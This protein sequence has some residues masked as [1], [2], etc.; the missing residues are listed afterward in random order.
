ME[1][2]I[3]F[4]QLIRR[5]QLGLLSTEEQSE[6]DEW[7]MDQPEAIER[8]QQGERR[9]LTAIESAVEERSPSWFGQAPA[10]AAMWLVLGIG[11]GLFGG[12][13]LDGNAPGDPALASANVHLL[14]TVR[15]VE[16]DAIAS[17]DIS[18]AEQ[19]T[20][21]LAQPDF[22]GAA[23]FRVT[24]DRYTGNEQAVDKNSSRDWYRVW[25]G[26]VGVGNEDMLAVSVRTEL[27]EPGIHRVEV[28][29]VDKNSAPVSTVR[30]LFMVE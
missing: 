22:E 16:V 17:Y 26:V 11:A 6:L 23:E 24:F 18:R 20:T 15:S 14:D 19:W 10:M 21:F 13:L 29:G 30:H 28:Q 27:M 12:S 1:N 7:L 4:Q 9:L 8:V 5:D 25:S 3:K 2:E